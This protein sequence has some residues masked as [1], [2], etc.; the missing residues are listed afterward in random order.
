VPL[1]FYVNIDRC[2]GCRSCEAACDVSWGTSPDVSF[3]QVGAFESGDFPSF[4]ERFLSLSCH[5]CETPLCML[6]CPTNA[7]SKR[8]DGVVTVD[9]DVCIGCKMCTWACPYGAPQYDP[10]TRVVTKC[11]F[12]Q[13][14]IDEGG[15]PRCVSSCPYDALDWG[16]MDEL[17]RRH[18]NAQ[19]SAPH[20]PDPN[21]TQPNILFEMLEDLPGDT[22][23]IDG[24]QRLAERAEG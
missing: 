13:P 5:H 18:P 12:C 6:S 20:F 17:V 21:L 11:H 16:E 1:G 4:V 23:R 8:D 15:E 19:R 2:V 24:T 10:A 14:L 9:P 7:Y 22:R 3:R